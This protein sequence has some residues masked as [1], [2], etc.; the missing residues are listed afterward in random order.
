MN[1]PAATADHMTKNIPTAILFREEGSRPRRFRT[2]STTLSFRGI[3]MR[4]ST[5][6]NM[7]SHAAGNW[8]FIWGDSEKRRSHQ[9][10]RENEKPA[11]SNC[12]PN[13][14]WQFLCSHMWV[15]GSTALSGYC[16]GTPRW[17]NLNTVR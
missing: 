3:S 17:P 10:L 1:S 7:V 12:S 13:R 8:N 11:Q 2:G 6:S 14:S 9:N 5:A 4:M 15:L 16:F